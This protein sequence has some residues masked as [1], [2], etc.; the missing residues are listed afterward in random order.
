MF[1]NFCGYGCFTI[2]FLYRGRTDVITTNY[3]DREVL[4]FGFIII[5]I[6]VY[7]DIYLDKLLQ[8]FLYA[9]FVLI[10]FSRMIISVVSHKF[11]SDNM[12]FVEIEH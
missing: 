1:V 11:D 4:G 2:R 3:S 12:G 6:I 7:R 8:I 5:D 9:G 10:L